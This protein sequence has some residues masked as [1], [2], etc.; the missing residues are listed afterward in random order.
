MVPEA[1][2]PIRHK[3]MSFIIREAKTDEFEKL[4]QL[5]VS[6]YSHL[7]DF[8]DQT[9]QPKYYE[10]LTNI[11]QLT[12]KPDTKLL[13]AV[14][15]DEELLGSVVYF[16]DMAQYGSGGTAVHEKHVAG[17]RLLTVDSRSRGMG[18]G[19]AL[20][21]KCIQLARKKKHKRVVIHT[22][23]AMKIAWK[24]Y[25]KLGFRRSPDL[26]FKQEELQVFGFRLEL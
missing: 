7:K 25:E 18:V 9:E 2:I 17:F 13:V 19:Q 12:D 23:N 6:V 14:S 10:M 11:G 3:A 26:D 22:T 24:M 8:P 15:D 21:N 1:H 4:G 16:S 20:S 5:M